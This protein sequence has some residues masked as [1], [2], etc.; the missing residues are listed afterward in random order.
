MCVDARQAHAVLSQMHNKT[1]ANDAALLSELA[2]TGFYRQV[3][4][5]R[6]EAQEQRALLKSR[7]LVVQQRVDLD[8]MIRSLLASFGAFWPKEPR[9]F[10]DRVL[11]AIDG[12]AFLKQLVEPLLA[13]RASIR[14]AIVEL[15]GRLRRLARDLEDCRRLMT[16]PGV[17]A[18]TAFAFLATVDEPKRFARSRSVG[19]YL[20]LTSRRYQSG[21]RDSSGRISK[22]GDRTM[23]TLLY[24]AASALITRTKAGNGAHLQ[25][26]ARALRARVGHKKAAVALARKLAVLLHRIWVDGTVFVPKANAEASA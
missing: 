21:E 9:R 26:W 12:N 1:D 24:E 6:L 4:V 17:G 13:L 7:E 3:A 2:R 20:G 15:D 18:V 11:A 25:A 8:N 22:R 5:K 19:A 14:R 10:P 16:V 23:R